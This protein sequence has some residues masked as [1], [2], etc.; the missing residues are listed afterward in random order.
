[1]RHCVL[2]YVDP[3]R[4]GCSY[5]YRVV[6]TQRATLELRLNQGRWRLAQ[7]FGKDNAPATPQTLDLIDRWLG[8]TEEFQLEFDEP[9][10]G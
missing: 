9:D 4:T 6:A 5:I 1:M 3:V 2:S 10:W 8:A 7:V